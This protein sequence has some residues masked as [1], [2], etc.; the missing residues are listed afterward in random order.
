MGVDGIALELT[1]RFGPNLDT[2]LRRCAGLAR[3]SAA[4]HGRDAPRLLQHWR[5]RIAILLARFWHAAV[6]NA[7]VSP[8]IAYLHAT[9]SPPPPDLSNQAGVGSDARA[10]LRIEVKGVEAGTTG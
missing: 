10:D 2:H 6:A 7:E 1:G 3:A 4:A 5:T 8:E 9:R